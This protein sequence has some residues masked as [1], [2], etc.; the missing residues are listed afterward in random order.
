MAS[1]DDGYQAGLT[2]AVGACLADPSQQA[3][4][5]RGFADAQAGRPP[6]P[7]NTNAPLV[8]PLDPSTPIASPQDG[9]MSTSDGTTGSPPVPPEFWE[10]PEPIDAYQPEEIEAD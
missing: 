6:D 1:Y 7:D 5:D 3:D 8:S 4:Y 9:T 2:G 10:A